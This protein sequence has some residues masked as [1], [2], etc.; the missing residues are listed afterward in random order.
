MKCFDLQVNG[1]F[2]TDFSNPAI[3]EDAFI[4]CVEKI[5]AKGVTRFLPTFPT[6][7]M[8]TYRRNLPMLDKLIDS[9]GL[10]YALPGFHIEGPFISKQPGAV[11][12]HNPAWVL[13]PDIKTL[14]ELISLANGHISILTVAAELPG[15][16]EFISHAHDK[17]ICVSLGHEIASEDD[18]N[19]SGADTMT[20]LGNGLPNLIDRHHNPIWTGL[21]KDDMTIMAITDGH[22]LPVNVLKC[23][24]RC[25]GVD[26]FIA[27]SDAC[28]VAGL[29]PGRYDSGINEGVLEPNG[30]YHNPAKKCLIGASML[31][32]ECAAVLKRE[33]L[34]SDADIE[35]VC[36]INP[37]A[38]L[39]LSF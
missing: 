26:R 4:R 22:H 33:N 34:L 3:T 20:H 16:K 13:P 5:L 29:P 17:G 24:L 18:I 35:R 28:F 31:L 27:V 25:K 37:H 6:S 21:S 14:D 39:K 7:A 23:Y 8:E 1:A 32:P 9:H 10:R 36:W 15:I 12:A 30:K 2:G 11:G 19:Q 38:L